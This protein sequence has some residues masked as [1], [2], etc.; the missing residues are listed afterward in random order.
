MGYQP[1]IGDYCRSAKGL[2]FI[3]ATIVTGICEMIGEFFRP[4]PKK[5]VHH[6]NPSSGFDAVEK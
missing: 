4:T 2:F 3:G 6:D 1:G 5:F